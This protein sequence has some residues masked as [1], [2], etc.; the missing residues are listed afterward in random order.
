MALTDLNSL[1]NVQSRIVAKKGI[2]CFQYLQLS[3]HELV[4]RISTEA[5]CNLLPHPKMVDTLTLW[6]A[7]CQLGEQDRPT[8]TAAPGCLAMAGRYPQVA[9]YFVV[10]GVAGCEALMC[11]LLSVEPD[12]PNANDLIL[13]PAV[14]TSSLDEDASIRPLLLLGGVADAL[15]EALLVVRGAE[16]VAA[17]RAANAFA[18]TPLSFSSRSWTR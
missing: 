12:V 6:A 5:L 17:A 15:K 1:D 2:S 3:N 16:G 7:F 4:R 13:R 14:A 9:R 10:D 18:T 11:A 8:T